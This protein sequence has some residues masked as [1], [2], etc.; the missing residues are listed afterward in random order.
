METQRQR[1]KHTQTDTGA[2]ANRKSEEKQRQTYI[3]REMRTHRETNTREGHA[4]RQRE[5]D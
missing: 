5:R 3:H 1:L 2:K 4:S